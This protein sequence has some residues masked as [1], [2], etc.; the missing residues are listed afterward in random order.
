MHLRHAVIAF[1]LVASACSQEPTGPIAIKDLPNI[2]TELALADIRK[3]ASDEFEGRAPGSK[4][5]ALT[6][7]YL[8]EQF[9]AAG[10]EPG[11]PDGTWTQAVPLVSLTPEKV[12]PLVVTT[13]TGKTHSFK[14]R[15]EFV[16][17]S[18]QV[19]E[20][21]SLAKSDMVFVGY[22]VQAPE[23][24]WDDFAGIDVKGK[25]IVVLVNDPQVTAP[26]SQ[27]LDPKIFKG[28]SMTYYGRW[29]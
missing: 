24:Q 11:N 16:P 23:Y 14:I 18:R 15:D 2:N 9:K 8:T 6:V 28:S 1:A 25:T 4:G 5:E 7:Q 17:F 21:V 26:N 27:S 3:L 12:S 19:T 10:L 29:T 20:S 13:K 22:G